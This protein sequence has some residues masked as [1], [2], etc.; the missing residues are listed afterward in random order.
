[1]A[2]NATARAQFTAFVEKVEPPPPAIGREPFIFTY[3]ETINGETTVATVTWQ[4]HATWGSDIVSESGFQGEGGPGSFAIYANQVLYH[5]FAD[6]NSYREERSTALSGLRGLLS[7]DCGEDRTCIQDDLEIM[8]DATPGGRIAGRAVTR[9]DC[10]WPPPYSPSTA[11]IDDELG[12][13]LKDGNGFEVTAIELN[14][15]IDAAIF[16]QTCPTTD[17]TPA[18][19]E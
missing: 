11:W 7:W 4:N 3:T 8:C 13:M 1:M 19:T 15:V 17:C 2:T 16:E 6:S 12:Y 10:D 18:P 14:P 9:Y 5:Y